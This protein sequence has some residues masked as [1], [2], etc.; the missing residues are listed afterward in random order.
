MLLLR[1]LVATSPTG[2]TRIKGSCCYPACQVQ[3][4]PLQQAHLPCCQFELQYM[5]IYII[6]LFGL[7]C[8]ALELAQHS[9]S[10]TWSS[11]K[12]VR[13]LQFEGNQR[14]NCLQTSDVV[15]TGGNK[16]PHQSPEL[17][18]I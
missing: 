1:L 7:I 8:V 18:K 10:E 13:E 3:G 2:E 12:S 6:S 15:D 14:N 4:C 11:V 9:T 5:Y 17:W 16:L